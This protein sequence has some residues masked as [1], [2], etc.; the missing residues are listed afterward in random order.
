MSDRELPENVVEGELARLIPIAKESEKERKATSVIMAGL[1]S[2]SEFARGMLSSIDAPATKTIKVS[3]FCEVVFKNGAEKENLRPDGMIVVT[4]GNRTWKALVEAKVG[5]AELEVTQIEN[6]LDL[7]RRYGV[8]AVI[9]ISNQFATLPTHHPV[10]VNGQ[11]LR[12]VSLYHWSWMAIISEAI[13]LI[14]NKGVSDPEQAYILTEIIRYLN[15]DKTGVL[16][17]VRMGKNWRNLCE[18]VRDNRAVTLANVTVVEVVEDWHQIGRY[19]AL[20][21]STATGAS[22]SV[23]LTAAHK[24]NPQTRVIDDLK[25]LQTEYCLY[26]ELSIPDAASRLYVCADIGRRVADVTMWL[27]PPQDKTRSTACI[28]WLLRQLADC[29]DGDLIIRSEFRKPSLN[30]CKSLSTVR[31]DQKAILPDDLSVIPSGFE[32]SR[33]SDN[34]TRFMG[35]QTFVEDI[36]DLV[37][38]FYADVGENLMA[39]VPS[40]PQVKEKVI[41]DTPIEL[42]VELQDNRPLIEPSAPSEEK[43]MLRGLLSRL[44]LH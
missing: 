31:E 17:T 8:D 10:K 42:Q 6:Y 1:M 23:A 20:E 39:W 32:I 34:V 38:G 11:K 27:K 14:E 3:C 30:T 12:S 35:Q 26:L 19:L 40:A 9:T 44:P 4:V 33:V 29:E 13:M 22:V 43:G 21:L 18:N 16:A 2:V 25:T 15:N 28:T 41:A 36:R 5:N 37:I 7:A 24:A